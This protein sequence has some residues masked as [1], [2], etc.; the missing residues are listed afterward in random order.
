ME[1]HAYYSKSTVYG[2]MNQYFTF[3]SNKWLESTIVNS[4]NKFIPQSHELL[5]AYTVHQHNR[6]SEFREQYKL[7]ENYHRQRDHN[8][9]NKMKHT[10]K[11]INVVL[12]TPITQCFLHQM[13]NNVTT[14][15]RNLPLF[16]TIIQQII[17]NQSSRISSSR[18]VAE[19]TST[20]MP[21]KS[22]KP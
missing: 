18:T 13:P 21:S 12:K 9:A 14:S 15:K 17:P 22:Q 1:A 10:V 4:L 6:K 2:D 8:S 5:G 3:C 7:R 11:L 20:A 16:P 19:V